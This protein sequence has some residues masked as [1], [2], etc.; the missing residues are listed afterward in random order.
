MIEINILYNG[1]QNENAILTFTNPI[2]WD[3]S[4]ELLGMTVEECWQSRV[5]GETPGESLV[6]YN[7]LDITDANNRRVLER[8]YPGIN[9]NFGPAA[10]YISEIQPDG[11]HRILVRQDTNGFLFQSKPIGSRL[12]VHENPYGLVIGSLLDLGR[13]TN[14]DLYISTYQKVKAII[15]A[16]GGPPEDED[17]TETQ[18]SSIGGIIG[19][20]AIG[21]LLYNFFKK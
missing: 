20:I 1:R 4:C 17:N 13:Y 2:K 21:T 19:F 11:S 16:S 7:I 12:N 10:L 3:L 6:P 14:S 8:K 5:R 9:Y 15:A 18:N